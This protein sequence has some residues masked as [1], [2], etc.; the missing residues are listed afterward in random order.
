MVSVKLGL[1]LYAGRVVVRVRVN[2][3]LMLVRRQRIQA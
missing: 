3:T 2:T 1:G